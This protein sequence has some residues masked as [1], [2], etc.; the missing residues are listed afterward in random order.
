MVWLL[1]LALLGA[2]LYLHSAGLPDFIKKPLLEKLRARGIELHFSRL[3]LRFYQGLVAD[4]VRFGQAHDP[5]SPQL[6]AAEVIL[7]LDP[8]ALLRLQVQVDAIG[9]RQGRLVWPLVET[10]GAPRELSVENIRAQLRFER[11]DKWAVDQF[12][13]TFGGAKFELSGT[14]ENASAVR[15]WKA[16]Q[17]QPVAPAEAQERL[18]EVSEIMDHVHFQTAPEFRLQINGDARDPR[19]FNI[20]LDVLAQGADTAWGAFTEGR[21][22]LRLLPG[23][24]SRIPR[25]DLTVRAASAKTPFADIANFQLDVHAASFEGLTHL[26][27]AELSASAAPPGTLPALR[28]VA[29]LSDAHLQVTAGRARTQWAALTNLQFNLDVAAAGEQT[30]SVNVGLSLLAEGVASKW[31]QA[32]NARLKSQWVHALTNAA[33]LSGH[34]QFGCEDASCSWGKAG[35]VDLD[36]AMARAAAGPADPVIATAAWWTN[37]TPFTAEVGLHLHEV[38][39]SN[40]QAR[41]INCGGHWQAPELTLTGLEALFDV[42]S[43]EAGAAL[44][45]ASRVF[46][47]HLTSEAD[48]HRFEPL[49]SGPAR[50]LLEQLAWQKPPLVIGQGELILPAWTNRQPDWPAQVQ[51]TLQLNGQFSLEHGGAFHTIPF[52]TAQSH[53]SY[54]NLTWRLPDLMATMPEGSIAAG[55]EAN[56]RTGQ[57]YWQVHSTVDVNRVRPLLDPATAGVLDLF[58]FTVPPRIEAQFWACSNKVASIGFQGRVFATNFTF[59]GETVASVETALQYTNGWLRFTDPRL[60]RPGGQEMSADS[61]GLEFSTQRLFLTNGVSTADPGAVTRAIG[62]NV[63]QALEPYQFSKPPTVHAHGIIPLRGTDDADLYFKVLGGPFQWWRFRLPMV[64]ANIHWFGQHVELADME[65]EFYGGKATGL[66]RFDFHP[67]AGAGFG[68]ALELN[69]A[70]LRPLVSSLAAQTNKLEGR[71]SGNLLIT[72]GNTDNWRQTQG[73]GSLNLRDGLIWDFPVFGVFSGVLNGIVPG[74]GYSRA[75]SASCTFGITNGVIRSSNLEIHSPSLRLDYRG[76]IALDGQLDARVEAQFLR[77]MWLVGPVV[78]TM[79]WPVTRI[80]EYKVTGT[81]DKPKAEPLYLL[82]RILMIPL[83]PLRSLKELQP[84]NPANTRTNTPPVHP[85]PPS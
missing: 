2:V 18:R 48:P 84:E 54:S 61:L 42:G 79:F 66:A 28:G 1:I 6:T 26:A 62:P 36:V 44:D 11:P 17:A 82:P 34:A 60:R 16:L 8:R 71:L 31:G 21:V 13:A 3:R 64:A 4:N 23:S 52:L 78:S 75:N 80:F 76:T 55:H 43:I 32:S 68:F 40:F 83:H 51:P 9:L 57:I 10:N 70:D 73:D 41:A 67:G 63:A 53:F 65:A 20:R 24:A 45:V 22:K 74:L 59:R 12:A 56:E 85:P 35:G 15:E 50:L 49:L 29:M 30:N 5:L 46:K 33:P 58:S 39:S 19:T 69:D 38:W 81:L 7:S 14:L 27:N 77:N 25:A 72:K 47:F 37:L